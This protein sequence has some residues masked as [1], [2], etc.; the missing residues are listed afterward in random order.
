MSHGLCLDWVSNTSAHVATYPRGRV[1]ALDGCLT[2]LSVY[3][4]DNYCSAHAHLAPPEKPV[5]L[6]MYYK[7]CDCCGDFK[8]GRSFRSDEAYWDGLATTCNKCLG[9][10]ATSIEHAVEIGW[11]NKGKRKQCL[12]CRRM[13]PAGL[14]HFAYNK[15]SKDLLARTCRECK[16]RE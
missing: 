7:E 5:R 8:N 9:E 16:E 15:N 1:C 13:L 11:L 6:S 4:P 10:T 12:V 14:L 3:N 2:T